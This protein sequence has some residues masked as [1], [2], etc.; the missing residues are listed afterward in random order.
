MK[1]E[2][3][4]LGDCMPRQRPPKTVEQRLDSIEIMLATILD[5]LNA[6]PNTTSTLNEFVAAGKAQG[7]SM[8]EI[9][10]M[11]GERLKAEEVAGTKTDC[12]P[13]IRDSKRGRKL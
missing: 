9:V 5:K 7:L 4:K 12:K 6:S 2:A 8:L 10:K 1:G 11:W 13:T 3:K